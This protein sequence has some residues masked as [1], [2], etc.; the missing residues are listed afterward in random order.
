Q[1]GCGLHRHRR[2]A[3]GRRRRDRGGRGGGGVHPRD[4]A[5][6]RVDRG[7][8]GHRR[9]GHRSDLR[10]GQ[11]AGLRDPDQAG[12]AERGAVRRPRLRERGLAA[13]HQ[14]HRQPCGLG[15][16]G[17]TVQPRPLSDARRRVVLVAGWVLVLLVALLLAGYLSGGWDW[18]G[19]Y[20][21]LVSALAALSLAAGTSRV[22][23][24]W[25]LL[26]YA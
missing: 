2:G 17:M 16:G 3:G 9:R 7:R 13:G 20:T 26:R 10:D 1:P 8:P 22:P 11:G 18:Y 14:R 25:R 21:L 24:R 6:P 12:G 4:P 23:T 19:G 5:R 15:A